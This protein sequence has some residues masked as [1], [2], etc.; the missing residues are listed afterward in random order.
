MAG[1][2]VIVP[3]AMV[4]VNGTPTIAWFE[5]TPSSGQMIA[6]AEDGTHGVL[7]F[8]ALRTFIATLVGPAT[9]GTISLIY[10][11]A[12]NVAVQQATTRFVIATAWIA[13]KKEALEALIME[14][15]LLLAQVPQALAASGLN[16]IVLKIAAFG[17]SGIIN[18][19]RMFKSASKLD[20]P[21]GANLVSPVTPAPFPG[22]QGTGNVTTSITP[23][24]R[25]I[26]PVGGVQ[27]AI[28]LTSLEVDNQLNASWQSG[29]VSSFEAS[30]LSAGSA[31]VTDANGNTVGSGIVGLAGACLDSHCHLRQQSIHRQRYRP[32]L[33]LRPGREQ[34]WRQWSVGQL[35]GDRYGQPFDSGNDRRPHPERS[36]SRGRDLHH[37]R[38]LDNARRQRAE[39]IAKLLRIGVDQRNRR[40][41][42]SGIW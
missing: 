40:H 19:F 38:R 6:V 2:V 20:P 18:A 11:Y 10:R 36:D 33:F 29:A 23:D 37:H 16:G 28:G 1:E 4:T 27:G 30:A 9:T 32:P 7:D 31:L 14:K 21:L 24:S 41:G 5:Y 13:N 3:S 26:V 8:T 15:D 12:F 22:L 17:R 25:F 39:C 35:L 34:P 42:P